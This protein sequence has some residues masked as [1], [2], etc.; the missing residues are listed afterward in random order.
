MKYT[1]KY[2]EKRDYKKIDIYYKGEYACTTT[3]SKTLKEAKMHYIERY[4]CNE[5]DVKCAY[6]K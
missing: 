6:S 2:G 5:N 4:L 1:I 3:W